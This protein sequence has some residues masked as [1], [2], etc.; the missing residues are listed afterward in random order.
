M[1]PVRVSFSCFYF[2]CLITL[3]KNPTERTLEKKDPDW[4]NVVVSVDESKFNVFGFDGRGMIWRK[5]NDNL[6]E[7]RGHSI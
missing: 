3:L 2:V 4:W 6:Q 5:K 7:E 1:Q